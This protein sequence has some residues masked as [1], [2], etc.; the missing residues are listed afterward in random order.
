MR[1]LQYP[2]IEHELSPL[3]VRSHEHTMGN[4]L[5]P[6]LELKLHPLLKA[7][8][9]REVRVVSKYDRSEGISPT[10]KLGKRFNFKRPTVVLNGRLAEVL[11][12]PGWDYVFHF[13]SIIA[14]YFANVGRE[15][16]VTCLLPT[17]QQCWHALRDSSLQKLPCVDTVILGYV[18]G[19]AF[20]S[21]DR[22]W[23][24][25]GDFLWKICKFR[26]RHSLLL[27]CKHT[28]WGEIA[29][30]IVTLLANRGVQAVIYSGKLGSLD[31]KHV[32][33]YCLAT[34]SSSLMPG[35]QIINWSNLFD[36]LND[37]AVK[38]GLHITVPSILQ[39]TLVWRKQQ[40]DYVKFVD[41]EIG[42][43]AVAAAEMGI[44]FSYLHIVSDN[45]A[46]KYSYDLSNERCNQVLENRAVLYKVIGQA[47]QNI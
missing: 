35:G 9:I 17:E 24:G 8:Y 28:Y 38:S 32:P 19:L 45:L 12:F 42:H 33:N 5:V 43:M 18:E 6:Y 36:T 47:L 11:C 7:S 13:G 30:R 2:P 46:T 31:S 1:Y 25:S 21:T 44:R 10:E 27:G 23:Q 16:H 41:P 22:E 20:L 37:P 4:S 40:K 34:G 15:V 29:G 14:S 26:S 39:E 3:A